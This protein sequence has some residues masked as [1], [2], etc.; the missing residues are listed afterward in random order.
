[1]AVRVVGFDGDD[2]L[3]HSETR[4]SVTQAEFRELLKRHV[5]EADVDARLAETEMKNL[6]IYGYGI[7][8]FT[9][10][11]LETA[12]ELTQ[13]RIPAS[14]LEVILGWGERMLIETPEPI[15]NAGH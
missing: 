7:K 14:D 13:A 1:M 12:I 5:A 6:S 15:D 4:F 2:T 10:S 3:W 11:M 9:L 8:S